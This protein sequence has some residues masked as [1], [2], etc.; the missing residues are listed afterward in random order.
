MK[1]KKLRKLVT[2]GAVRVVYKDGENVKKESFRSMDAVPDTFDDSE[3]VYVAG[4][5]NIEIESKKNDELITVRGIE[6]RLSDKYTDDKKKKSDKDKK[7][8]KDKKKD[9]K[10]KKKLA[11][12]MGLDDIITDPSLDKD[13][14]DNVL[15]DKEESEE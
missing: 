3:L 8:K 4:C 13:P 5:D 7:H 9:K 2:R 14:I 15:S 11:K 6:A 10:E 1:F 12:E